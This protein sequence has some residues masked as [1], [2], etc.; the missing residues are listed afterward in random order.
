MAA[1]SQP[2]LGLCRAT[3][4]VSS[5]ALPLVLPVNFRLVDEV[6]YFRTGRGTTLDAATRDA[7]VAFEVDDI[8]SLSHSGWSVV[9]TGLARVLTSVEA[10]RVSDDWGVP[11]WATDGDG[12]IVALSTDVVSGRRGVRAE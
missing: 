9:V 6:I 5:G 1:L 8:E 10:R 4:S 12:R 11:P 7:V 3:C 2:A